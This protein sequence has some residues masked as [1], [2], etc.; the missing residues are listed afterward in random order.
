[1]PLPLLVEHHLAAW[2][3]E[4]VLLGSLHQAEG[5]P[6]SLSHPIYFRLRLSIIHQRRHPQ[7]TRDQLQE[8]MFDTV[9]HGVGAGA[10]KGNI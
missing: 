3:F 9:G 8:H 2:L 7:E 6:P 1:M 4:N 5:A 10:A